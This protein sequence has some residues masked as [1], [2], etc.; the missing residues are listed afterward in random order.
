LARGKSF[1][2]PASSPAIFLGEGGK[3][4]EG[5]STTNLKGRS[6]GSS[7]LADGEEGRL[8]KKK[9]KCPISQAPRE[10]GDA[11]AT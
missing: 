3:E 11:Y 5:N 6:C 9:N 7:A 2:K 1:R 10:T 8:G 4:L